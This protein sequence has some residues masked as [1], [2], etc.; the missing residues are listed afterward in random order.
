VFVGSNSALVAPV[1]LNDDATIGA[2][3]VISKDAPAAQLTLAR[4]KQMSL[5]NWKRPQ[6]KPKE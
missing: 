5:P 1:T 6:K 4:A 2:G 3:S